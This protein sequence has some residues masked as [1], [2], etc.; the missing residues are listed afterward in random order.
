MSR[1][2]DLGAILDTTTFISIL[3]PL[4]SCYQLQGGN[5]PRCCYGSLE[6]NPNHPFWWRDWWLDTIFSGPRSS[7]Y[8]RYQIPHVDQEG[9]IF[10]QNSTTF[11][12]HVTNSLSE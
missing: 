7:H 2:L 1:L 12:S 6:H 10:D 11:S 5:G 8:Q 9:W 4:G 3:V